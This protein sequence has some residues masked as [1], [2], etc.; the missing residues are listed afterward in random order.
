[1]G[2]NVVTRLPALTQLTPVGR[3]A[4]QLVVTGDALRW[5]QWLGDGPVLDI[6]GNLAQVSV[7]VAIKGKLSNPAEAAPRR[8]SNPG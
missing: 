4:G 3:T 6:T 2:D 5:H 1:M 7:T 8:T